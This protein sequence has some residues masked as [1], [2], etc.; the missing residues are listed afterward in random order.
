MA[1]SRR[2]AIAQQLVAAALKGFAGATIINVDGVTLQG[3]VQ[4]QRRSR[5]ITA[6]AV[7]MKDV[8][9]TSGAKGKLLLQVGDLYGATVDQSWL[10]LAR[11]PWQR[12]DAG[13]RASTSCAP[14]SG[15]TPSY[16]FHF[17]LELGSVGV[18]Y[19]ANPG[20]NLFSV[21]GVTTDSLGVRLALNVD[22]DGQ[23]FL[24]GGAVRADR[25]GL[26][27]GPSFQGSSQ[28]GNPVAQSLLASG[29]SGSAT[30]SGAVNPT[31]GT[32]F[33][34]IDKIYFAFRPDGSSDPGGQTEMI[35]L[36]VQRSVRAAAMPAD[37]R[38]IG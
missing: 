14:A 30:G 35:W 17:G 21:E 7:T 6:V 20:Q 25:I 5:P 13:P 10:A 31:F 16:S 3:N 24:I 11:L 8:A 2:A 12:A 33:G 27:L 18:D 37:R 22:Q 1:T 29:G 38:R 9:L 28:S 32:T 26:P 15:G 23:N 34:Y 19:V 36:P 4:S